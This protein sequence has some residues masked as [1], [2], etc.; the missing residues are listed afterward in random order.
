MAEILVRV[1]DVDLK[2]GEEV[3]HYS[4]TVDGH[5]T[6]MDLCDAHAGPFAPL[7]APKE[8]TPTR[9]PTPQ[10]R[11]A[12]AKPAPRNSRRKVTTLAEIEAMKTS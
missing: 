2:P 5:T 7:E 10:K 8:P 11:A 12:S 9:V 6:E 1:C 3:R 4:V